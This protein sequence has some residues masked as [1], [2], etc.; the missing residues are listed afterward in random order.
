MQRT[1]PSIDEMVAGAKR[2]EQRVATFIPQDTALCEVAKAVEQ[3]A[4]HASV[5]IRRMKGP[6]S[7]SKIRLCVILRGL[8]GG[9]WWIYT[10]YFHVEAVRLAVTATESPLLRDQPA[11]KLDAR[12]VEGYPVVPKIPPQ[13]V[14]P[15]LAWTG[16]PTLFERAGYQ[17]VPRK[18]VSRP[19]FISN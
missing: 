2:V 7:L 17:E 1:E 9:V 16:V 13:P 3:A 15:A 8:I 12:K 19:I 18:G 11:E 5:Q 14:P 6:L 4:R 10:N